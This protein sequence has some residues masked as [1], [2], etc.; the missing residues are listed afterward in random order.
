MI[1][2]KK[3]PSQF[4][5][6]HRTCSKQNIILAFKT[7]NQMRLV[8]MSVRSLLF[9]ITYPKILEH[10]VL[11]SNINALY[12]IPTPR[13]LYLYR[14]RNNKSSSPLHW[15]SPR[16]QSVTRQVQ[17]GIAGPLYFLVIYTPSIL[18]RKRARHSLSH[19]GPSLAYLSPH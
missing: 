16:L 18:T 6:F 8:Y 19:T 2:P 9:L 10:L 15:L 12:I 11:S 3:P 7:S 14:C 5:N 1:I 17:L 13:H 4:V